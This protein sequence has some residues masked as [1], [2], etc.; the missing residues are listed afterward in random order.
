MKPMQQPRITPDSIEKTPDTLRPTLTTR[1][2]LRR[3]R[4]AEY[5]CCNRWWRSGPILIH[6]AQAHGLSRSSAEHLRAAARTH[7]PACTDSLLCVRCRRPARDHVRCTSC[8]QLLHG[9]ELGWKRCT[10]CTG[11]RAGDGL[12]IVT[13][14]RQDPVALPAAHPRALTRSERSLIADIGDHL[15]GDRCPRPAT[16]PPEAVPVGP[17]ADAP[18][19]PSLLQSSL[20]DV[21]ET[22]YYPTARAVIRHLRLAA[23]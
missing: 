12:G 23:R 7:H 2:G 22:P 6:L 9:L 20:C 1:R 15:W 13:T 16:A 19:A 21:E 5:R 18:A 11:T 8:E 10:W 3:S 17:K 4:G 14:T